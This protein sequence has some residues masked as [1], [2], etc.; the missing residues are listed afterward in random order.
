MPAGVPILPS[1][2]IRQSNVLADASL[3]DIREPFFSALKKKG[4][5]ANL[6]FQ[7][8]KRKVVHGKLYHEVLAA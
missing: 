6:T 2:G 4:Y 7:L 5:S 8:E 1:L 3:S